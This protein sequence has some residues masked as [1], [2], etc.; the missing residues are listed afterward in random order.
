MDAATAANFVT[1]QDDNSA[2]SQALIRSRSTRKVA[3][4]LPKSPRK[5]KE[6]IS[7]LANKFK[8]R[9]KP[10]QLKAGGP[11][12]GLAEVKNNGSKTF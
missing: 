12:N 7:A 9:V 5:R 11:K 10:N 1:E 8:L 6:L 3:K 2:F 4:T